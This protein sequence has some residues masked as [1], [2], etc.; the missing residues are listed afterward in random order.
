VI[1]TFTEDDHSGD[2]FSPNEDL[3]VQFECRWNAVAD[4]FERSFALAPYAM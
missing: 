1:S 2:G 3:G 4:P